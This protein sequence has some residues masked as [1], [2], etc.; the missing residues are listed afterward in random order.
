[1]VAGSSSL[2]QLNQKTVILLFFYLLIPGVLPAQE[3]NTRVFYRIFF[4]DKGAYSATD[5]TLGDLFTPKAVER[6]KKTGQTAPDFHDLPVSVE[7]IEKIS[8]T[9]LSLHCKSRWMNTALFEREGPADTEELERMQFIKQIQEITVNDLKGPFSDK[10]AFNLAEDDNQD[11]T[12]PLDMLN[13]I[14]LHNSGFTG[15]GILIAV[16]DGGFSNAEKISSLENLRKRNGIKGTWDFVEKSPD[17]YTFHDHG[18][19]V[20]SILAGNLPGELAGSAPGASYLLLRTEDT[21]AEYPAEEDFWTAGAEYA[22]SLGADIISSSLGYCTFDNPFYNY[23]YSDLDGQTAFVTKAAGIAASRGIVV[24]N[25]AGNERDNDWKYII[26]PSDA[27]NVISVGAVDINREISAFSSAGPSFDG[28]VKPD[29]S[30]MGVAV[31]LQVNE[32]YAE[33]SSGTSFSCPLISGMC[34][35]LLQAVPLATGMEIVTSL[36]KSSDRSLSP[37]TLYGYGIPDFKA[38]LQKLQE[39]YVFKPSGTPVVSPNPFTD[40]ITV[41]FAE[42]PSTL[43]IGIFNLNGKLMFSRDYNNFAGRS[44]TLEVFS[45]FAEGLYILRIRTAK[46]ESVH[47]IIRINGRP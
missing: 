13:G 23:K 36:R 25:S 9:G 26:A 45:N 21:F 41:T 6:R 38:A 43:G 27:E 31:P 22:D 32:M 39:E 29:V 19:A 1:M 15:N 14:S 8:A 7:Y 10:L 18:T 47:R 17:V 42:D 12:F 24:V 37:D 16:L 33:N 11:Y 3:D 28:R 5:Y 20:L 46:G 30:A 2:N 40:K 44:A 34:A 4:T 35:C